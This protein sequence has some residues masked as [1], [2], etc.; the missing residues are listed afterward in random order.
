MKLKQEMATVEY[1]EARLWDSIRE[2]DVNRAEYTD[3]EL[4][5]AFEQLQELSNY[6]KQKIAKD[7]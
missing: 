4:R 1:L 7:R 5:R 3:Q 6:I 2:I